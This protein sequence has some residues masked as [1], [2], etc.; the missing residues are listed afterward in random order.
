MTRK[1]GLLS[2]MRAVVVGGMVALAACQ[3]ERPVP[4]VYEVENTGAGYAVPVMPMVADL[5]VIREF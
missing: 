1:S 5:P 4:L 2:A 3:S